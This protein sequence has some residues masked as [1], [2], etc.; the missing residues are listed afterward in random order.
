MTMTRRIVF[1][2]SIIGAA[3]AGGAAGA[4]SGVFSKPRV[5]QAMRADTAPTI[6]G[7]VD[8]EC[9]KR[10]PEITDF[11]SRNTEVRATVQSY[12]YICYDQS[13]LYIAMKCPIRKG[14]R[15]FGGPGAHD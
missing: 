11:L 15:P 2:L 7:R 13:N 9:W 4:E 12:A 3:Y 5:I 14:T 10:A 1:L 6:D 8:D